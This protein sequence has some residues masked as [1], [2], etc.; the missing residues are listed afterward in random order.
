MI[1]LKLFLEFEMFDKKIKIELEVDL[2]KIIF[3]FVV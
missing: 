2:I 3:K 1:M